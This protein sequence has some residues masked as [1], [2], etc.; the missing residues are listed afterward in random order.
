MEESLIGHFL[1][2]AYLCDEGVTWKRQS[3][4]MRGKREEGGEGRGNSSSSLTDRC[5]TYDC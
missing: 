3:A 5:T 1:I 4:G 2:F